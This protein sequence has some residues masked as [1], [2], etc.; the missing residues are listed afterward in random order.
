ME[1]NSSS[2]QLKDQPGSEGKDGQWILCCLGQLLTLVENWKRLRYAPFCRDGGGCSWKPL[3]QG[4]QSEG[5]EHQEKYMAQKQ[6]VRAEDLQ[7]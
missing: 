3:S 7:F 2:S 6:E 4:R 5:L 1:A